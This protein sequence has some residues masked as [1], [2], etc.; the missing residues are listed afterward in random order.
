FYRTSAFK[1]FIRQ[2]AADGHYLG[3]H[4]DKHL[5]YNKWDSQRTLNVSE[6]KFKKDLQA[7]YTEM[8]NFGIKKED[9]HYFMPPYEWYNKDIALWTYQ[10]ELSLINFS[11]GT[12]SHTDYT[13]PDMG[14]KYH[15]NKEIYQSIMI[16]EAKNTLNGFIMLIHIGA[17]PKRTEKFYTKLDELIEELENKGYEF[18]RIDE[19]LDKAYRK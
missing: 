13:T 16:Y 12:L 5:L 6:A 14:D 9:A 15:D 10:E 3:A 11:S 2:L 7:N 8:A 4:S 17:D 19:M 1:P 18:V